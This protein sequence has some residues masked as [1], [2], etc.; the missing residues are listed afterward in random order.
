MSM[1]QTIWKHAQQ[2]STRLE[3]EPRAVTIGGKRTV[4]IN[5]EQTDGFLD[6]I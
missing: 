5:E 2:P 6:E 4:D 1:I 3:S